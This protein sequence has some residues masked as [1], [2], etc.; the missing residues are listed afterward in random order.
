MYTH[1]GRGRSPLF[2]FPI[3][4]K[5]SSRN[6][7]TKPK[8]TNPPH[9]TGCVLISQSMA[10][11]IYHQNIGCLPKQAVVFLVLMFNS[12]GLHY[13]RSVCI[14]IKSHGESWYFCMLRSGHKSRLSFWM[15]E[16]RH[17]FHFP[18]LGYFLQLSGVCAA[19]WPGYD[20]GSDLYYSL[21]FKVCSLLP[22]MRLMSVTWRGAQK[23]ITNP[24]FCVP[25]P[26]FLFNRLHFLVPWDCHFGSR[27]KKY[28]ISCSWFFCTCDYGHIW[29]IVKKC[30]D[31]EGKRK[32]RG[33][34]F[35]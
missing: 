19:R 34:A 35:L 16:F 24:S 11:Q 26:S 30:K 13:I 4:T 3:Q 23:H 15:W 18:S 10:H 7:K 22:G 28:G 1:I 2:S 31:T 25:R 17:H 5:I 21:I 6:T 27:G 12:F 29:A 14:L 20:L 8:Q 33:L 9:F 32:H